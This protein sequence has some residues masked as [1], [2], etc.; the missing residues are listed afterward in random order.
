MSKNA[1]SGF[2]MINDHL[3]EFCSQITFHVSG[4]NKYIYPKNNKSQNA[5][6]INKVRRSKLYFDFIFSNYKGWP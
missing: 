4:N 6:L 1:D 5:I 2:T 3:Q